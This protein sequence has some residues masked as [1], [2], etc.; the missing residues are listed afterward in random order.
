LPASV[1]IPACINHGRCF[2]NGKPKICREGCILCGYCAA[3]PEF[4][5]RVV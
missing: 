3:F 2:E 5:F 4:F 1:R